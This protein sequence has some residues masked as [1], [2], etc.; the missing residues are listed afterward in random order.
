MQERLAAQEVYESGFLTKEFRE[1]IEVS[2]K[3]IR[4]GE[5][6]VGQGGEMS[7]SPTVQIA[8]IRQMYLEM[9]GLGGLGLPPAVYGVVEKICL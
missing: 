7:A 1:A 8:M 3:S 6:F 5:P 9:E 2:G 4:V